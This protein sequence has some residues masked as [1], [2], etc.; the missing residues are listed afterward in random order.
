MKKIDLTARHPEPRGI[1]RWFASK[2]P[3]SLISRALPAIHTTTSPAKPLHAPRSSGKILLV[4]DDPII[5]KTTSMKLEARGYTVTTATDGPGAL[6]AVRKDKPDVILLDINLPPDVGAVDWN[7]VVVMSWLRRLEE[8]K[9]TPFIFI[10][11][12]NS[13]AYKDRALAAGASGFFAKP[14]PHDELLRM[15]DRNVS[16]NAASQPMESDTTYQI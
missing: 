13:T 11:G 3:A 6:G 4:D 2:P 12:H 7:G 9:H 5:L 10:T 14:I 15:I 8:L 1:L 16:E